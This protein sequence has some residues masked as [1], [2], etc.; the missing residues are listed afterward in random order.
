MMKRGI[1]LAAG[2]ALAM[3]LATPVPAKADPPSWA[4]AH[5]YRAKQHKGHKRDYTRHGNELFVSDGGFLRCNRD[6]V[7]AII[8]G[9]A[10]AVLGSTVGK[11]S[12]RDAAMIGGAILGMLS[13]YS[14]GQTLD[15]GDQ[16]CT[17]YALQR[18]P[19]GQHVRWQ[20]PDSGRSYN[21]VPTNSWQNA[22]GRYCREYSA[23][24][25]IG[26][27]LQKTFGTACRQADGSW[28]IVS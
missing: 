19:D 17:G 16:A 6:V 23:T 3:P 11:G 25:N 7:G 27:E 12:G 24:A 28:Q 18:A 13:G 8:G 10:G 1:L 2:L 14:I 15:Q 4:P 22:E 26:G 20:N 9:G 21:V 5:G